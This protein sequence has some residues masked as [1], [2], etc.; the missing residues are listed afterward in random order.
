M[1]YCRAKFKNEEFRKKVVEHNS[2]NFYMRLNFFL[3]NLRDSDQN[4]PALTNHLFK[5]FFCEGLDAQFF[6][7][8]EFGA[9]IFTNDH[10]VHLL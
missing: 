4:I 5:F 9:G 10:E 8:V 7:F 6:G 1:L 3:L 2:W